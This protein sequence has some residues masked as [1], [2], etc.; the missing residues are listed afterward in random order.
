MLLRRRMSACATI[1]E[2]KLKSLRR[3]SA[4]FLSFPPVPHTCASLFEGKPKSRQKLKLF[5]SLVFLQYHL[6]VELTL[7]VAYRASSLRVLLRRRVSAS[8]TG[9]DFPIAN[10]CPPPRFILFFPLPQYIIISFYP[11]RCQ[12]TA[13]TVFPP[14]NPIKKHAKILLSFLCFA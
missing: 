12:V 11:P 2:G 14:L 6:S 4:L 8:A 5:S 3:Q 9:F 1:S 13:L 10:A 7:R